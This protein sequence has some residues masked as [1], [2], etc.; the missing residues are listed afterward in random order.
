M[1]HG[2]TRTAVMRA[3]LLAGDK[4]PRHANTIERGGGSGEESHMT[5][6][7]MGCT[8]IRVRYVGR[9]E[10]TGLPTECDEGHAEE[11]RSTSDHHGEKHCTGRWTEHVTV[12]QLPSKILHH[13][14]L[15][16]TRKEQPPVITQPNSIEQSASKHLVPPCHTREVHTDITWQKVSFAQLH[17]EEL[18]LHIKKFEFQM[19][20][21][22][23]I[24]R[25]SSALT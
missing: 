8:Q 10:E 24:C 21:W 13:M 18:K 14:L 19:K 5:T 20:A 2:V 12:D 22:F 23:T 15:A 4:K 1:E 7:V 9:R 16:C 11:L 6:P 25:Q 17:S 3:P